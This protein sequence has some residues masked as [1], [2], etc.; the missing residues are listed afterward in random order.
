MSD[1]W[2]PVVYA[3]TR[4]ADK[5]WRVLPEDADQSWL[6][7]C[8]RTVVHGG[9]GLVQA[10]RF[11]LAQDGYRRLVGVACQASALSRTMNSDGQRD[12]YGFVGWVGPQANSAGPVGPSI[13][14]TERLYM[15]WAGPVY[16]EWMG[17]DWDLHESQLTG[18][19]QPPAAP[20]PW[21]SQDERPLRRHPEWAFSPFEAYV[22]PE[23][24]RA[25]PWDLARTDARPVTVVIGFRSI[26]DVPVEDGLM[27]TAADVG[28]PTQINTRTT[29]HSRS[30][31]EQS[32]AAPDR[33]KFEHDPGLAGVEGDR[34][35]PGVWKL[36]TRKPRPENPGD[37]RN[38]GAE[39]GHYPH[40]AD[41]VRGSIRKV[42]SKL[43]GLVEPSP[44][45]P[46]SNDPHSP[47]TAR[48]ADSVSRHA[49]DAGTRA[50]TGAAGDA[51]RRSPSR[52]TDALPVD[53]GASHKQGEPPSSPAESDVETAGSA[54]VEGGSCSP[55]PVKEA[56]QCGSAVRAEGAERNP[57]SEATDPGQI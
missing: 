9:R 38:V 46:V 5:W 34:G 39:E 48:S 16:E 23:R 2:F 22:W 55:G 28:S 53:E 33:G 35:N 19:H 4:R 3:R 31:S 12:L 29:R 45:E 54:P 40:A 14:A 25:I 17:R 57:I 8:V 50:E 49:Q 43:A 30:E 21:C 1:R 15:E 47:L 11:I 32:P 18:P 20:P 26:H 7:A 36:A 51:E 6:R 13:E 37:Q 27:V 41:R 10:P 42:R 52:R 44:D 24:Q 56:G